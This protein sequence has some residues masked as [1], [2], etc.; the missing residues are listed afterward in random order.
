MCS[1]FNDQNITTESVVMRQK[2]IFF[3]TKYNRYFEFIMIFEENVKPLNV[4]H[5][6]FF[7]FQISSKIVLLFCAWL[8]NCVAITYF[9]L[10]RKIKMF[11][12]DKKI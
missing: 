9:L 12:F 3:Q 7:F 4:D 6:P 5:K 2:K 10:H 11:F 1:K 8:S